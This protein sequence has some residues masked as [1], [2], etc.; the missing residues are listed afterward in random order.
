MEFA[1]RAS[2]PPA[3]GSWSTRRSDTEHAAS[4]RVARA[5]EDGHRGSQRVCWQVGHGAAAHRAD[6]CAC[7]R[8]GSGGAGVRHGGSIHAGA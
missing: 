5:R 2:L 8:D 7:R 6:R 4:G 1:G 3:R